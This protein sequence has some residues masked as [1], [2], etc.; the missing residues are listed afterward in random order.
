[1]D[2][3]SFSEV[4]RDFEITKGMSCKVCNLDKIILYMDGSKNLFRELKLNFSCDCRCYIDDV[5]QLDDAQLK[6]AMVGLK[7]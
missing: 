2:I 7:T 1:M 5:H 3:A 6:P 4:L